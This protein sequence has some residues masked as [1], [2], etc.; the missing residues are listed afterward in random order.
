[1]AF[2]HRMEESAFEAEAAGQD[3]LESAKADPRVFDPAELKLRRP[4]R[5]RV[6]LNEVQFL[7]PP[8]QTKKG[9]SS[10]DPFLFVGVA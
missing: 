8:L 1:M 9:P 10:R 6:L 4:K 2:A 7:A 5:S 3:W